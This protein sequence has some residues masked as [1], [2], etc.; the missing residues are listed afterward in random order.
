MFNRITRNSPVLRLNWYLND[1]KAL[2]SRWTVENAMLGAAHKPFAW[3]G[4]GNFPDDVDDPHWPGV[5]HG[6]SLCV[7]GAFSQRKL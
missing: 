3:C 1:E 4:S 6:A 7:G 2:R 5:P